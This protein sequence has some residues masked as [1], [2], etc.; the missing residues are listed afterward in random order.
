MGPGRTRKGGSTPRRPPPPISPP[1]DPP[2]TRPGR[3]KLHARQDRVHRIGRALRAHRRAGWGEEGRRAA[4][5]RPRTA[6]GCADPARRARPAQ[7][8]PSPLLPEGHGQTV[9]ADPGLLLFLYRGCA[10]RIA[11]GVQPPKAGSLFFCR[12]LDFR[13]DEAVLFFFQAED[14]IRDLI[15]TGV[16]TCALPI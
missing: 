12:N 2:P 8:I 16:Q 13:S 3:R 1:T 14:G 6:R 9:T 11:E 15:V 4:P 10:F 5:A 7:G